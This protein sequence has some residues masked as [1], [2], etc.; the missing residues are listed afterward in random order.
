MGNLLNYYAQ[1]Q[2]LLIPLA[3]PSN[4][5]KLKINFERAFYLMFCVGLSSVKTNMIH[6]VA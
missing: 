6:T 3:F 1:T 5:L 2:I 4:K